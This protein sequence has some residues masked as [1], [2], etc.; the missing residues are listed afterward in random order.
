MRLRFCVIALVA[1]PIGGCHRPVALAP[2]PVANTYCWWASQYVSI[3]PAFVAEYFNRGLGDAGFANVKWSRNADSAW[4]IAGPQRIER[5]G[6]SALYTFRVVAH[7]A[8]ETTECAWR[9]APDAD[10]IRRPRGAQSCFH[11]QVVVVMPRD[12]FQSGD[13]SMARSY[14]LPLCGDVYRSSLAG[15]ELLK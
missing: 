13:S 14:I 4:A 12:G 6:T 2:T 8:T 10:V 3:S 11:T 9:G 15:L 5:S 7:P 1:I